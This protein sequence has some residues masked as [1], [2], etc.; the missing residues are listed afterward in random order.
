MKKI[1]D[2]ILF[3]CLLTALLALSGC[4]QPANRS[5]TTLGSAKLSS[6]TYEVKAPAAGKLLGLISEPG[7]RISKDQPLFAIA[8][9]EL[10]A[11]LKEL[12]VQKVRLES[13]L[14]QSQTAG[15]AAPDS[16]LLAQAQASYAAAQQRAAKMNRLLAQGAVSRNQ[17]QAAQTE[18]L[19]AQAALNQ[20]RS[21]RTV[22]LSAE[23]KAAKSK[24]LEELT[25]KLQALQAQQQSLEALSPC[26]GIITAVRLTN[27]AEAA[28]DQTVVELRATDSCT[29]TLPLPQAL[30]GQLQPGQSV[31]LRAAN[32][33]SFK[34]RISSI[35]NGQLT[36][37][38]GQKPE[39]LP[40]GTQVEV[41]LST[42]D[43]SKG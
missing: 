16:A 43:S 11:Q 19:Q 18:L 27:D 40:D 21:P 35:A 38:S 26:T 17:A 23:A 42:T 14:S 41:S 4:S 3:C 37:S 30:A 32:G 8:A 25:K 28:K 20:A 10:D 6:P 34:G 22:A 5:Q 12:A 39:D 15:H 31:T 24:Q 33:D 9:P 29:L 13:E 2:S 1:Y 36:I 7:E